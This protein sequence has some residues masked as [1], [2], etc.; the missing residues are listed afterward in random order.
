MEK[1]LAI[2]VSDS[3]KRCIFEKRQCEFAQN[4]CGS[5]ECKAPN[6][7]AMHCRK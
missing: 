2:K 3:T 6:D 5:F 1:G 7:N 4:D